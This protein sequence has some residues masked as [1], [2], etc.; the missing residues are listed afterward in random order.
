[1]FEFMAAERLGGDLLSLF[2]TFLLDDALGVR[3]GV[4]VEDDEM[5]SLTNNVGVIRTEGDTYT[6]SLNVRYPKNAEFDDI[7]GRMTERFKAKGGKVTVDNHQKVLY[8]DLGSPLVK[9]L[10]DVYRKHTGDNDAK[11]LSIGG[12][13]F[14]RVMPNVVAYGPHFHGKPTYIHQK[15]EFIDIDDFLAATAIYAEALYELAK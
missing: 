12:G 11:P 2:E 6:I 10:M 3:L 1:V 7:V 14:A 5:G 15:D 4:H 13:T 8:K 9:T